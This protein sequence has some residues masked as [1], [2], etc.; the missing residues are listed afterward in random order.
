MGD[1]VRQ[2]ARANLARAEKL[3]KALQAGA[4][5]SF[6]PAELSSGSVPCAEISCS[7][8]GSPSPASTLHFFEQMFQASP[9]ALSIADCA[10][11]VLW[12]NETF[13]NVFGYTLPDVIGHSLENLV[14]PSDRLA[15][16][17]WVHEVLAR[18]ERVT[19]ETKR[20]KKDGTLVDVS[21]S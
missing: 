4:P 3:K 13:L 11:R 18:G 8:P 5:P 2:P 21:L 20:R 10:H 14:V 19:L 16:S 7:I 6:V 9:D 17:K 15:E 12:A 1:G